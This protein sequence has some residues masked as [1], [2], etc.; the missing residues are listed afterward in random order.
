MLKMEVPAQSLRDSPTLEYIEYCIAYHFPK[1]VPWNTSPSHV[2]E[3]AKF[4]VVFKKHYQL[5]SFSEEFTC[6]LAY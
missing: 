3:E 4:F 5:Y 6:V 1:C 2:P